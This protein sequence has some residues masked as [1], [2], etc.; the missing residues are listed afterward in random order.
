MAGLLTVDGWL[1]LLVLLASVALLVCLELEEPMVLAVP[2]VRREG[3][4][5]T[6]WTGSQGHPLIPHWLMPLA[7]FLLG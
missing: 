3:M 2:Q 6:V 1:A 4:A 5:R 7:T